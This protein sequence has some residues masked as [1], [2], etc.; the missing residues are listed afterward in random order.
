MTKKSKNKINKG[1]CNL[2]Q[3]DEGSLRHIPIHSQGKL[4]NWVKGGLASVLLRHS[5][6]TFDDGRSNIISSEFWGQSTSMSQN[7]VYENN[8]S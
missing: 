7:T 2:S 4:N 8:N 5:I 6:G 3:G 1:S